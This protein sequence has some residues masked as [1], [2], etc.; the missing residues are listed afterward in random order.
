M[1]SHVSTLSGPT[2]NFLSQTRLLTLTD[3]IL[4]I[5]CHIIFALLGYS[6]M[7]YSVCLCQSFLVYHV[8]DVDQHTNTCLVCTTFAHR[9]I[10]IYDIPEILTVIVTRG[11]LS[12]CVTRSL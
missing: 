10:I 11:K 4:S 6:I 5:V 9:I 12:K 2:D 3:I 1:N 7:S 8:M